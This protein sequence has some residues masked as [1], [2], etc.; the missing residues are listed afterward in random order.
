MD[1]NQ[2]QPETNEIKKVIKP[3]K[4]TSKCFECKKKL[5]L[6]KYECQCNHKFCIDCLQPEVHNCQFD[7]IEQ[8]KSKL[9][10]NLIKVIKPKIKVI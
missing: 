9:E 6:M 8:N 1:T 2:K 7:Y 3:K 5:G 10:V 4:K